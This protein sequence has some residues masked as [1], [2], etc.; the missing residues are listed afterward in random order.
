M[1]RVF[2]Q[3]FNLFVVCADISHFSER[4]N[5]PFFEYTH[6]PYTN[7][8]FNSFIS[9]FISTSTSFILHARNWDGMVKPPTTKNKMRNV[10]WKKHSHIS[11]FSITNPVYVYQRSA[12]K[13]FFPFLDSYFFQNI[14][15]QNWS[16]SHIS[17]L[18]SPCIRK[19]VSLFQRF[20][21]PW[22]VVIMVIN[23]VK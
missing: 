11:L 16:F 8:L 17:R 22:S 9:Y 15:Q 18:I 23:P 19:V 12:Y 1:Y 20:C 10:M 21:E 14:L 6:L 5:K 7:V 3:F 13:K 4:I 2:T